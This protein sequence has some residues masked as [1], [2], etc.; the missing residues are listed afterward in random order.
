MEPL[1]TP[2]STPA[3]R[4]TQI[5]ARLQQLRELA[6]SHL[7]ARAES[8]VDTSPEKRFGRIEF[9]LRDQVHR[10]AAEAHQVVLEGDK[11]G[12][13]RV[14]P[15]LPP[16]PGRCPIR[17]QPNP[18]RPDRDRPCST[19]AG[20]LPLPLVWRRSLSGRSSTRS[21]RALPSRRLRT[22]E[23]DRHPRTVRKSRR[24]P[25]PPFGLEGHS[26]ELPDRDRDPGRTTRSAIGGRHAVRPGSAT[27]A[28]GFPVARTRRRVVLR[29]GCRPRPGCVFG[30]DARSRGETG[31]KDDVRRVAVR[32][33]EGT[34]DLPHRARPTVVGRADA[35]GGHRLRV[36]PGRTGDCLDR[37]GQRPGGH[38][39]ESFRRERGVCPG[40]LARLGTPPRLGQAGSGNASRCTSVVATR[41]GGGRRRTPVRCG[42]SGVRG[43]T[44][45]S[46]GRRSSPSP[47]GSDPGV[48]GAAPGPTG[49]AGEAARTG[50]G[51]RGHLGRGPGQ[52]SQ[53]W[54]RW[55][56]A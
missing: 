45:R 22:G 53:P 10:L 16:P 37:R 52:T 42:G 11:K 1:S 21:G 35:T 29:D 6:E 30:A 39:V 46:T 25:A 4:E 34:P 9:E 32:P 19:L 43:A 20:L 44:G 38:L 51:R 27:K 17:R 36:R 3:D 7:R 50:H 2:D 13:P 8:L 56:G 14:E 47:E 55:L 40:L 31:M 5:Q 24:P 26:R 49:S 48:R 18:K 15:R 41:A 54:G 23:P 33:E 28:L 12:L